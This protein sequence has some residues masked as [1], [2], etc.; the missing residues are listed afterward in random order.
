MKMGYFQILAV[1]FI[2]AGLF[3]VISGYAFQTMLT[4]RVVDSDG[5][6]VNDAYL[7]LTCE[8]PDLGYAPF[9]GYTNTDGYVNIEYHGTIWWWVCSKTGY[10]ESSG[11]GTPPS[12]IVLKKP[13]DVNGGDD[14]F[15]LPFDIPMEYVGF[16]LIGVGACL[17]LFGR[18]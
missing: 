11:D 8:V 17:F 10:I 3:L 16:G 4:R 9:D 5:N 7:K 12:T 2:V 15:D 13:G 1:I 6:G 14:E 18:R